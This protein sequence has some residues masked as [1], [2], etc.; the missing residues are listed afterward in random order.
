MLT[1]NK[2]ISCIAT[3]KR[4]FL[5][6]SDFDSM[7]CTN[8]FTPIL[9][10]LVPWPLKKQTNKNRDSLA[11]TASHSKYYNYRIA[12]KFGEDF[13]LAVWRIVKNHQIKFSPIIKHDVIRNTH[14]HGLSTSNI[15][16]VLN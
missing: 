3:A 6:A 2:V 15:H 1:R 12:G 14:A 8:T 10:A 9:V 7:A 16:Y 5:I 13:N 4:R 11:R